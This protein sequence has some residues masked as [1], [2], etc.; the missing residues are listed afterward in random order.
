MKGDNGPVKN[1]GASLLPLLLIAIIFSMAYTARS[2]TSSSA[3]EEIR[4]SQI[5]REAV[6]FLPQINNGSKP[7]CAK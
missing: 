7:R 3:R 6:R 2:Q 1:P 4:R 5:R